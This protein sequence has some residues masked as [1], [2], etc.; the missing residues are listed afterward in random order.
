LYEV[1]FSKLTSFNLL[2]NNNANL[3]QKLL[4]K[5]DLL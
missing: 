4:N 3:L 2:V 1:S 5:N